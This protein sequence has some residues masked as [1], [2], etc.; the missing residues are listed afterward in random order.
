MILKI[1]I[2]NNKIKK[3][4]KRI[5]VWIQKKKELKE[6][7]KQ[8]F[9]FFKENIQVSIQIRLHKYYK[10]TSENPALLLSLISTINELIPEIYFSSENPIEKSEMLNLENV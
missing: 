7:L 10:V 3:K 5:T 9:Q 4:N 6:D 8:L 2:Q 1:K